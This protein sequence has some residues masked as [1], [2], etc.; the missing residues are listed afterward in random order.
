VRSELISGIIQ[1]E[2]EGTDASVASSF[3]NV[4]PAQVENE[5]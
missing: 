2:Y 4:N 5:D 3:I 1:L